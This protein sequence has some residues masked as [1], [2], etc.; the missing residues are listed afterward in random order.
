MAA[1]GIIVFL[2]AMFIFCL[3]HFGENPE[4]SIVWLLISGGILAYIIYAVAKE[5]AVGSSSVRDTTDPKNIIGYRNEER[6][7]IHKYC[8][9]TYGNYEDKT[10]I[11]SA[12]YKSAM[13]NLRERYGMPG[14]DTYIATK[15]KEA[16]WQQGIY[17]KAQLD[18]IGEMAVRSHHAQLKEQE[19]VEV[20][21]EQIEEVPMDYFDDYKKPPRDIF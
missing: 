17:G 5:N 12:G 21:P 11:Y 20:K 10:G 9:E 18:I 14:T 19:V 15:A 16:A 7:I 8:S 6:E 3:T 1:V 13:A 2:V 4:G